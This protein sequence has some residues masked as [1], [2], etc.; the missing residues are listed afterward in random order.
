L[1]TLAEKVVARSGK[2]LPIVVAQEGR[3]V[4]YSG[5]NRR[6]R[7]EIPGLRLTPLDEALG[8]LYEWYEGHRDLIR[9]VALL[10]DK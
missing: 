4:E 10:V 8:E 1:R 2:D 6:L 7:E 5:D 3:G 9:R